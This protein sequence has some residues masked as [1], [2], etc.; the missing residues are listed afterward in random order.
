MPIV[1]VDEGLVRR[2]EASAVS[3]TMQVVNALCAVDDA[4]PAAAQQMFGGAAIAMGADRYVNRALGVTLDER[5][6]ADIDAIEQFFA[7]RALPAAVEVSSWAP[8]STI[9]ELTRRGFQPAW[10]RSMFTMS[11]TVR[12]APMA[13]DVLVEAV[14]DTNIDAWIDTYAVGFGVADGL[15][16][17]IN[18][19]IALAT[20][21][22]PD[23]RLVLATVDGKP[24]GCGAVHVAEGVAWLGG[25]AT[26]PAFRR[27]GVQATLVA[28]RL[29]MA[30]ELGCDIAA[31]TAV[32]S[33]ASARNLVRLGW[34]LV[35]TQLVVQ[36]PPQS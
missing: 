17:A 10:F 26:M 16:R 4:H 15:P 31:A 11:P 29:R 7:E 28:H 22:C 20:R 5:S 35:Q 6:P 14:D 24:A 12:H 21:V 27:H 33:G 32:P 3:T 1:D 23:A 36:Q 9:A 8:A 34:Q 13:P 25:G 30:T 2:L 19:E 18:D